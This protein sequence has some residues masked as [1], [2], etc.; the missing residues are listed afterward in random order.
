[1]PNSP[2][3]DIPHYRGK[4]ITPESPRP[5]HIP[6][7][8]NIPVL[9]KQID[10]IFNLMSTH[11]E[12]PHALRD[13]TE[14]DFEIGRTASANEAA[15]KSNTQS[16]GDG[17]VF[18]TQFQTSYGNAS[19]ENGNSISLGMEDLTAEREQAESSLNQIQ[20]S[21]LAD[22]HPTSMASFDTSPTLTQ[23]QTDPN[24][25]SLSFSKDPTQNFAEPSEPYQATP[26]LQ[27]HPASAVNDDA[28]SKRMGNNEE[29]SEAGGS[30]GVNYQSLLDNISPSSTAAPPV[31]DFPVAATASPSEPVDIPATSNNNSL[32]AATLPAPA[33]LPPRPPPQEKP[34]IH[35]NYVPGEDIRSYHYPHNHHAN[36]HTNHSSQPSNSYRPPQSY[37][38]SVVAAGAPGTSSAPNGLPPPPLATFQQLPRH[39]EQAQRSPNVP[40]P[41][42]RD[43][44]GRINHGMGMPSGGR[45]DDAPWG[46][47]TQR[48]Y[49]QFLSDERVYTA[50]GTWDK[51]P[52][53]SRLF[54]G[55]RKPLTFTLEIYAHCIHRKLA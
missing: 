14:M 33:G 30:G 26:T 10:P 20:T 38:H 45:D 55:K 15:H 36:T 49:D 32:P 54:V 7:P 12:A 8:S 35:P 21:L 16:S 25:H 1:M 34:A 27:S 39:P 5:I 13:L 3:P 6:E 51:F 41:Q 18:D 9:A 19:G 52:Q 17:M 23:T 40:H 44:P 22:Q 42:Q 46:P 31:P 11:M 50:E 24:P 2:L 47:E 53:G 48:D 4:T 29:D 28:G 37:A 43:L